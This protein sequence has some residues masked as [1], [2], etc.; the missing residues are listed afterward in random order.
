MKV[1]ISGGGTG[2]H[3]S[4]AAA[5]VEELRRRDPRLLVQWVGKAG[6][7]EERVA[8][9]I[10]VPFR[11]IPVEG[12]PR[13]KSIRRAWVAV[14]MAAGLARATTHLRKFRPQVVIGVGGYVSVPLL[15]TA[16]R[17]DVPTVIHEQNKHLGMANQLIAQKAARI[18]LGYEDTQGDFDAAKARFV[19]NPV[20]AG[21]AD[22]PDKEAAKRT[23]EM[24]PGLPLVLIVGGSQGAQSINRAV[25][26]ALPLFRPDEAQFLWMTGQAG[27]NSARD[28]AA[29]VPIRTAVFSFIEDMVTACAAA[30]LVICRAGAST[31]AE[32]ATMGKPSVLVPYPHATDNHQEANARAFEQAGAAQVVLDGELDGPGTAERIRALLGAPDRLR[33]M[34][35]A[36]RTLAP[37]GAA[38]TIVADI[39]ELV[40]GP[41]QEKP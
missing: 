18:Y 19:G 13:N 3:T 17:F 6:G 26:K 29:K 36:A 27:A 9:R 35:E 4:P 1:M 22:P 21:F 16:Q 12:W 31:T 20:R 28:A 7:I 41:V 34:G 15:W 39:L 23:L 30:D 14:K 37:P 10:E 25:M 32:I 40:F 2:G 11:A 8:Q 33:Q 38:E 5:L 24:D